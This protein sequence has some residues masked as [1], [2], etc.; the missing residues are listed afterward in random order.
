M[1]SVGFL[2]SVGYLGATQAATREQGANPSKAQS[3]GFF[4]GAVSESE[5][6]AVLRRDRTQLGG[7]GGLGGP[8]SGPSLRV[9]IGKNKGDP[10]VMGLLKSSMFPLQQ[11]LEGEGGGRRARACAVNSHED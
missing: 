5:G 1:T 11:V 7:L 3:E 9:T 10:V 2:V 8:S 6:G 4:Y